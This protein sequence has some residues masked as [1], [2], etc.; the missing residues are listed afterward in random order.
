MEFI[1]SL[2]GL[3]KISDMI[4]NNIEIE[5]LILNLFQTYTNTIQHSVYSELMTHI[6][7]LNKSSSNKFSFN[8]IIL[9]FLMN[10][11]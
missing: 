11:N 10:F 2:F 8:K 9:Y 4:Q 3:M 5:N 7:A 1:K 6:T